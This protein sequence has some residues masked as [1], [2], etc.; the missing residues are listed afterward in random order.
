MEKYRSWPV[1]RSSSPPSHNKIRH[2]FPARV[3][4]VGLVL[5]ACATTA[6][7][8]P[9]DAYK[10]MAY[11]TLRLL[12]PALSRVLWRHDH[13]LV[14]AVRSLEIETASRLASDAAANRLSKETL[15]DLEGRIDRIVEM[16]DSRRSFR[17]ISI[18]FGRL[19]RVAADLSDPM[20]IGA[21]SPDFVRVSGEYRRFAEL[22]LHQVP[23]VV[24]KN[25]P[26]PLSGASVL[27]L[28][29][30]NRQ[31][32]THS[33]GDLSEAF[34]KNGRVVPA[35]TFDFRSIP[36][37]RFSLAYSRS[38]TTASYLW[39][40]AWSRANGDFTGYKFGNDDA[41]K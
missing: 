15:D 32:T 11:D 39:L 40:M 35:E 38:V 13:E 9:A 34:W 16:I 26:H 18:E 19:L 24:D 1:P 14:A 4:I 27:E 29:A 23:L 3:S 17:E 12:P 8:W 37:A 2:F 25:L 20:L 28:L 41:R 10:N 6:F 7:G 22:N 5:F 33:V 31:S 30:A 36:Y 21:G